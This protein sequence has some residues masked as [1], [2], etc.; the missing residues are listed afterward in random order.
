M[1]INI[2]RRIVLLFVW[3]KA[4]PK[5]TRIARN[6]TVITYNE[7]ISEVKKCYFQ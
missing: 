7:R 6:T 5:Q 3:D 2:I 1:Y 4:N